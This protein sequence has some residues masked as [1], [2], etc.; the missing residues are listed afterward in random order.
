[1]P[2]R[3]AVPTRQLGPRC[4]LVMTRGPVPASARSWQRALIGFLCSVLAAHCVPPP[5]PLAPVMVAGG[6]PPATVDLSGLALSPGAHEVELDVA[7]DGPRSAEIWL[8]ERAEPRTLVIVLHGTV[9]QRPGVRGGSARGQTRSLVGCLAAP[10]LAS[11]D[12][13]IIA[14]LSSDGQWWRRS[15]TALVLGLVAAVRRRWPEAGARSVL[16]GYSN[17]GIGTWYFARLYADYFAAAVPMAFD[18]SIVGES[19]L[20]IYGIMGTSD[21]QFDSRRVRVAV[22]ALK[23]KGADVTLNEK[24]RGSHY[25][26]C[27]YVPELSQAGRWLEEHALARP[28]RPPG[29]PR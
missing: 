13:I 29:P 8:P 22:Q 21:E 14:P 11:L 25:K 23:A 7:G 6:V 28:P 18:E 16:M 1:M 5:P 9:V 20:P 26:A 27:S 10:A 17:G 15:D 19:A 24:Y 2:Q 4:R 12:P 3:Q